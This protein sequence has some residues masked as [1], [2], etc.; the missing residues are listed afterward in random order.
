MSPT[1]L[2]SGDQQVIRRCLS[3]FSTKDKKLGV[4]IVL[5]NIFLGILDLLGV[6]A[7]GLVG[8]L[9]FFGISSGKTNPSVENFFN[10]FGL[11]GLSFQAQ[12]AILTVGACTL[13]I[14]RTI[15]SMFLSRRILHFLSRRSALISSNLLG[16]I[17][18]LPIY[19]IQKRSANEII[20]ILDNGVSAIALG[21]V[22]SVLILASDAVLLIV[23]FIGLLFVN[24]SVALTSFMAFSLIGVLLFLNT[25]KR[26]RRIGLANAEYT[27]LSNRLVF[28][29]LDNYREV[30]VKDRI[31]YY[32]SRIFQARKKV[33]SSIAEQQFLPTIGK[34]V[35]ESS[36]I[37]LALFVSAF[38]FLVYDAPTAISSLAIFLASGSRFAPLVMRLQQYAIQ[39][40]SSSGLANPALNVLDELHE[41]TALSVE[42]PTILLPKIKNDHRTNEEFIPNIHL[43]DV[44]F[45]YENDKLW[46]LEIPSL[47][48]PAGAQVA[49]V[50]P[51]G[52]G[53][54]TLVDIILGII[55]PIK[56][57]VIV[58]K[59]KAREAIK[60]WPGGIGYVPQ[61]ITAFKGSL[62]EN[63]IL[64]GG[65]METDLARVKEVVELSQLNWGSNSADI[66]QEQVTDG[67][68]NMSGGQLQR[69]GIARALY[70]NPKLIALD[71]ATSA[72][73]G[74]TEEAISVAINSLKG[75]STVLLIAHRL[76]SVR[77]ADLVIYVEN[78][79]ILASGTIFEVRERVPNFEK[80]AKLMGL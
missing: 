11:I 72:L 5:T 23:M 4:L 17:T 47:D 35:I 45:N 74:Q 28:E 34:Y 18:R 40:K 73:D 29:L 14:T 57:E 26:A 21:V 25:H 42:I 58:S 50:G 55:E 43:K 27:L 63:I 30:F 60:M 56:G 24:P 59:L 20:Y 3:V 66:L 54:S 64:G 33:A 65:D 61:K 75:K 46:R 37:F 6:I 76:S 69:L 7:I 53:K 49:I 32:E 10:N 52:G 79:K 70:S 36:V 44:E 68:T 8:S 2:I 77:N 78:G 67:G 39:I 9:A 1:E 62:L 41:E 80:Q 22:G 71:E 16:R 38:Q 12:A 31:E 19:K 13:F 15:L 48:I 51:S